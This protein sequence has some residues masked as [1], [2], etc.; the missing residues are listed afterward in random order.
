MGKNGLTGAGMVVVLLLL[1]PAVATALPDEVLVLHFDEG[2]GNVVSDASGNGHSGLIYDATWSDGVSGK[3]LEFNGVNSYVDLG[4]PQISI[5]QG[6]I[7]AWIF[8]REVRCCQQIVSVRDT[9]LQNTLQLYLTSLPGLGFSIDANGKRV[10]AMQSILTPN[11]W[12]H[13]VVVHDGTTSSFFIDGKQQPSEGS[14]A[15]FDDV[16][17]ADEYA[18]GRMRS[19]PEYYFNGR[20]DE[21]AVYSRPLSLGEVQTH[22]ASKRAGFGAAPITTT[23][24]TATATVPT[25]TPLPPAQAEI[26]KSLNLGRAYVGQVVTVTIMIK[27][28]GSGNLYNLRLN[29]TPPAA[30]QF[31]SGDYQG[32]Y[33]SLSPNETKILQYTIRPQ[34]TGSFTLSPA[35]LRYILPTGRAFTINSSTPNIDV[36]PEPPVTATTTELPGFSWVL[37]GAGLIIVLAARRIRRN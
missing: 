27:N 33:S 22:F 16:R 6:S 8:P 25:G 13:V 36:I 37:A 20:I 12:H 31:V 17:G 9:S 5:A 18:I 15:W 30:F 2:K 23:V 21:V 35:S 3:G 1:L 24:T 32:S 7:E 10:I 14:S 28:T 19:T 11:T 4:N 34:N 29:D 26:T